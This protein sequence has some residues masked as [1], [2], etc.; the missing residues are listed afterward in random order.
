MTKFFFRIITDCCSPGVEKEITSFLN[1]S[2]SPSGMCAEPM[3]PYWKNPDQG[4]LSGSFLC[5]R[6]IAEVQTVFAS[7]WESAVA[8]ARWSNLCIPHTVFI[9]LTT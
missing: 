8:D 6:S 9:W 5:S 3:K 4:E 1:S 2:L 7:H